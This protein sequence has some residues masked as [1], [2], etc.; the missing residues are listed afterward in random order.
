MSGT[1][2]AGVAYTI[3]NSTQLTLSYKYWGIDF[4][5]YGSNDDYSVSQ[6]GVNLGLRL[7]FD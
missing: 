6:S 7:F 1:A 4:A 5:G 3:G 2:Q